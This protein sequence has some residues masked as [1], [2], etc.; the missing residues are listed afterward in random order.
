MTANGTVE[1]TVKFYSTP[2][3]QA[4][5][6]S[7]IRIEIRCGDRIFWASV[8]NKSFNKFCRTAEEAADWVG[9]LKGKLGQIEGN[10]FEVLD[11]GLQCFEKQSKAE[12]S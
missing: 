2:N 11:A 12:A 10:Q 4:D 5:S 6:P 7:R 9:A 3:S 8:K 1:V